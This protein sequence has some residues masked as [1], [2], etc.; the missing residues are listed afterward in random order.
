MAGGKPEC[1]PGPEGAVAVAAEAKALREA[2]IAFLK[3]ARCGCASLPLPP[4]P[5]PEPRLGRTSTSGNPPLHTRAMRLQHCVPQESADSC[6]PPS[7][8]VRITLEPS[9]LLMVLCSGRAQIIQG[10][11]SRR[12]VRRRY[13]LAVTKY[14][15]PVAGINAALQLHEPLQPPRKRSAAACSQLAESSVAAARSEPG[16]SGSANQRRRTHEAHRAGTRSPSGQP[17]SCSVWHLP[18]THQG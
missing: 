18:G 4:L 10:P 11:T 3:R 17:S 6:L 8:I 13:A 15:A 12:G 16:R 7:R 5:C 14:V 1:A 2:N 9:F